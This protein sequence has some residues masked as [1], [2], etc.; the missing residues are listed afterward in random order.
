MGQV[1]LKNQ[2]CDHCASSDALQ[3]YEDG[4]KCFSC[5]Y[6]SSTTTRF[7]GVIPK[8]YNPDLPTDLISMLHIPLQLEVG[9]LATAMGIPSLAW[10]WLWD[11]GIFAD[12][13]SLYQIKYSPSWQRVIIPSYYLGK[14]IGWQ[15]RAIYPNQTPKYIQAE[16]AKPN[17]FYSQDLRHG[18]VV[19]WVFIVEDAVSAMILGQYHPTI[20]ILG[21]SLDY[22]GFK[23]N[24]LK[25]VAPNYV[26][27][28]DSDRAGRDGAIKI[29]KSLDSIGLVVD[30]VYTEKDPKYC[31]ANTIRQII[32]RVNG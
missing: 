7:T 22:A 9:Q 15:G 14:G 26:L 17:L 19:D 2:P 21:S 8:S 25:L 29:E 32:K 4:K 28:L 6:S 30:N 12:L 27:W 1:I 10:R 23:A 24:A 18:K 13:I 11:N 20:S 16:G 5:G 31:D 3:V